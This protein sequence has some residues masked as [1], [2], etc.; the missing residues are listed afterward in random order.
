[1]TTSILSSWWRTRTT[2]STCAVAAMAL[3]AC[4]HDSP[5]TGPKL[6]AGVSCAVA[7]G[8]ATVTLG[9]LQTTTVDCS[10]GGTLFDLAGNGASYLLVP[11]LAVGDVAITPTTYTFGAPSATSA[12]MVADRLTAGSTAMQA[13]VLQRDGGGRPATRQ[14]AFDARLLAANRQV[15]RLASRSP[16]FARS[17]AARSVATPD[18]GTTRAFRVIASAD[19]NVSTVFKTVGARLAYVGTNVLLYVDTL[20]ASD[21]FATGDLSGI[22]DLFDKTLY[23]IDVAAFGQPSDIDQNGHLIMLMTPVVNALVSAADCNTGGF[24]AGFFTGFDVASTSTNSNQGEVFYT[25]AP[26]PAGVSSCAHTVAE[27]ERT[28]PATFLHEVQHL[29]NFT[30]HVIVHGGNDGEEGWLDEGLSIVAEELG[31]RY[32]EKKFPSPSGRTN[33]LQL[34]PDSSQ[35]FISGLLADSY[36]YLLQPDTA[37]VTLHSD[38]DLG[39]A[40]RGSVWLLAR[41][42]GDL[43]GEEVYKRLEATALTGTTNIE[44]ATG[45]PFPKLFGDFGIALYTDSIVGVARTLVPQRDRFVTRNLRQMY[46]ALFR[47]AGG[48]PSVPRAF[49]IVTRSVTATQAVTASMVPGTVTY[50]RVDTPPGGASVRLRFASGTGAALAGSLHPQVAIIRLPPGS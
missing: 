24:I 6:T 12:A 41:W 4:S 36:N 49:P 40:W 33:P 45:E 18:V 48:S 43:K 35:G 16:S 5:S 14:R 26:D 31:S 2:L 37:T 50:Y 44:A 7:S 10:Q 9:T 17:S 23:P 34:F 1:M 46:A 28:V 15:A 29:I 22:G 32:Y 27:I 39:L 42:L 47:A 19:A 38:S 25:I 11:E 20:T 8:A 30:Q 3:S 21:G 13:S